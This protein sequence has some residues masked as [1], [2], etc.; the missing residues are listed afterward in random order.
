MNDPYRTPAERSERSCFVVGEHVRVTSPG[1]YYNG[2]HAGC[3][4]V[5]AIAP[6]HPERLFI[7]NFAGR[8]CGAFYADELT[9]GIE[10]TLSPEALDRLGRMARAR[11]G[12]S[13]SAVVEEIVMAAPVRPTRKKEA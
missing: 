6:D 11:K 9:S 7:V 8:G 3:D 10:L 13:R 2:S 4:G 12:A 5:I 1:P